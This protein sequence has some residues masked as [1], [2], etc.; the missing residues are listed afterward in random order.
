MSD[1]TQ[2]VRG[3]FLGAVKKN[4]GLT[5]AMGL[6]VLLMGILA[7]GS[8]FLAG[9][10][11]VLMA[12]IVLIVGG[13]GQLI[14]ALKARAGLFSILIA[15]LTFV[16]GGYMLANPGAALGS[17]TLFLAAYFVISGI[18]EA[19]VAFQARPVSGWG[20]S[21]FSGIISVILGAMIWNQ[22]PVSGA[23]AIGILLGVRL[24]L[25]GWTL[26]MF[27]SVARGAANELAKT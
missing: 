4:S 22:F 8:P 5:I 24:V 26:I 25:G 14:F 12:G 1:N 23:W 18:F 10:S 9:L 19:L 6:M 17:L 15:V 16:I 21:L 3:E 7:I 13:V 2:N 11:V 20:W 27:G